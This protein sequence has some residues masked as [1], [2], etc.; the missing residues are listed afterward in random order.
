V[1]QIGALVRAMALRADL[2]QHAHD[3]ATAS[4]WGRAVAT[5]WR[6]AEPNLRPVVAHMR[7]ISSH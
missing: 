3:P 2:A 1:V 7:D 4:L 5:L 6:N